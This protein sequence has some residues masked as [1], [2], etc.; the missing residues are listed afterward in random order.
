MI[1]EVIFQ[2]RKNVCNAYN[3]NGVNAR[4]DFVIFEKICN[5]TVVFLFLISDRSSPPLRKLYQ[6]LIIEMKVI[7]EYQAERRKCFML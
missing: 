4:G 5:F 1:N 7:T 6:L 2:S 3:I